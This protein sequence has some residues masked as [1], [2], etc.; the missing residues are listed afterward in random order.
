M[1]LTENDNYCYCGYCYCY[2]YCCSD[3]GYDAARPAQDDPPT[4]LERGCFA[5]GK[6]VRRRGGRHGAPQASVSA[7]FV[8]VVAVV[9]VVVVVASSCFFRR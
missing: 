6:T 5:V 1:I 3:G 4:L 7:P 2:C 8:V 9:A